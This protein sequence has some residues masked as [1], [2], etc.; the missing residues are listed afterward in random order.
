MVAQRGGP[1]QA[2]PCAVG[3][4][5]SLRL[6]DADGIARWYGGRVP[7]RRAATDVWVWHRVLARRAVRDRCSG[8]RFG[9]PIAPV[10]PRLPQIGMPI[11]SG[12]TRPPKIGMPIALVHT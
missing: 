9:M 1:K 2:N 6:R 10:P 12:R 7:W 8:R 3:V 11:A 5:A 4:P